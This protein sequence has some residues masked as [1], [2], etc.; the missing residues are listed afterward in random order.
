MTRH[1]KKQAAA[2][3]RKPADDA[4]HMHPRYRV[5]FRGAGRIVEEA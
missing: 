2:Q 5:P 1:E 4:R 3:V